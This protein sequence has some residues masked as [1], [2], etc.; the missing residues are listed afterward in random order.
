MFV[1]QATKKLRL[2]GIHSMIA[3]VSARSMEAH[4]E[5]MEAG[6]DDYLE[7]PLTAAKLSSIIN[8]II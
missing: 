3:G 2:M 6:L 8:K 4:K 1:Y 7:K 5:F